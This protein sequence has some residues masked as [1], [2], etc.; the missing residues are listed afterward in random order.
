MIGTAADVPVKTDVESIKK[1]AGIKTAP[2][3]A[4]K[5]SP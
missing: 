3:P 4:G 2:E 5:K 1:D